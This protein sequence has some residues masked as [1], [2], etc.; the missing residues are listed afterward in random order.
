MYVYFVD[1]KSNWSDNDFSEQDSTPYYMAPEGIEIGTRCKITPKGDI[2]AD[3]IPKEELAALKQQEEKEGYFSKACTS[4]DSIANRR[5]QTIPAD[6]RTDI[7]GEKKER[8]KTYTGTWQNFYQKCQ[9]LRFD[10]DI[11]HKTEARQSATW[12][13]MRITLY[14]QRKRAIKNAL[15]KMGVDELKNFDAKDPK[16]WEGLE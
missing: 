1:G 10:S 8:A 4:V 13:V 11:I 15:K 6:K 3:P 9:N 14:S 2:V 5:I 16:H 12:V 7:L